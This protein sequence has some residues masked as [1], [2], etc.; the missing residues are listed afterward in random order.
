MR[1]LLILVLAAAALMDLRPVFAETL[2][3]S[4]APAVLQPAE[5][6][7]TAGLRF[8]AGAG[9]ARGNTLFSPYGLYSAF[10]MAY[11]CARGNTASEIRGFFGFPEDVAQHRREAV[12]LRRGLI[13]SVRGSG[14]RRVNAFWYQKGYGFLPEY[15]AVLKSSYSA[16]G[17]TADFRASAEKAR[18][19]ID[20]WTVKKTGGLVTGIF[21]QAAVTLFTRLML[22][23][24]V[25]F[26]GKWASRFSRDGTS[27]QEFSLAG[28][29]KVKA[30]L[31]TR[32]KPVKT[33]YY[34]DE[35]L[36]AAGLDYLGG[37]L[38]M[39]V[40]LPAPGKSAADVSKFLSPEK[41]A[42]LRK[43]M[44]ARVEPVLV[45][46]PR[47]KISGAWDLAARLSALGMPLAF[48]ENADYS[49]MT[50]RKGLFL[51]QAVQKVFL[52]VDEE[53]AEVP[54][55]SRKARKKREKKPL[56]F[57]ADRPFL[58]LI[59]EKRTGLLLF[60]GR[61]EDPGPAAAL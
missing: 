5:R 53:G 35:E 45:S 6:S 52:E 9:E 13:R 38:R 4:T 51:Q 17:E 56:V 61:L 7:N 36:Q 32:D 49:G 12:L 55:V 3:L 30:L 21:E 33:E 34:E 41:L 46:L 10:S 43:A 24:A 16:F 15:E 60:L 44:S 50:G 40:L 42:E 26:K 57:R 29:E 48:S 25:T 18:A 47:F 2:A 20:D 54:A 19:A 58:F 11:D 1:K 23:N 28:G 39:L 37:R 59:E 27:E 14:F 31:M 8:D 22:A